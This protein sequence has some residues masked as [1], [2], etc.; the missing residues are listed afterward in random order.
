M[1]VMYGPVIM[2]LEP[3]AEN[4]G[5]NLRLPADAPTKTLGDNGTGRVPETLVKLKNES[6][7]QVTRTLVPYAFTEK[8]ICAFAQARTE[9]NDA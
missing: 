5:Q 8:R 4:D 9:E 1:G 2:A 3:Q 7:E 6:N